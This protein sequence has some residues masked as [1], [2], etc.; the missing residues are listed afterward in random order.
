MKMQGNLIVKP[1]AAT[2]KKNMDYF[3]NM[4]P[5]IIFKIGSQSQQSTVCNSGGKNPTWK[6]SI[7]F[8]IDGGDNILKMTSFDSDMFKSDDYLADA[9][10]D[11]SKIPPGREIQVTVPAERKGKNFG[12]IALSFEF[13]PDPVFVDQTVN[14]R[15]LDY[16]R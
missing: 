16:R 4:D 3:K 5:Y 1:R 11:I 15:Q 14:Q 13:R 7:A 6:D 12:M 9:I 8:R 2:F 10:Y